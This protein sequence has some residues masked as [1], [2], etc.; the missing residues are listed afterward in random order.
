M[1]T[2][3]PLDT[4]TLKTALSPQAL[5]PHEKYGA[6]EAY[7]FGPTR[8]ELYLGTLEAPP[9]VRIHTGRNWLVLADVSNVQPMQGGGVLID[10]SLQGQKPHCSININGL[11]EI[12]FLYW[13]PFSLKIIR[14]VSL[15]IMRYG[16]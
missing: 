8:V 9:I 2:H 4:T 3:F 15:S 7:Q 12:A 1:E 14:Q 10:C 16:Q 11:G 13:L 6:G 5:E